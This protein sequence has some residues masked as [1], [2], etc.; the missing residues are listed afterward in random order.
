MPWRLLHE[1]RTK[2]Q[3]PS[4]ACGWNE[5]FFVKRA[6]PSIAACSR[7]RAPLDFACGWGIKNRDNPSLFFIERFKANWGQIA[8]A[9]FLEA[10]GGSGAG[11]SCLGALVGR[12]ILLTGSSRRIAVAHVH[13]CNGAK[14]QDA[15]E[16]KN[17][18]F[19]LTPANFFAK[20]S[21]VPSHR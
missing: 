16:M 12:G 19:G 20:P 17:A 6:A 4:L 10:L 8:L 13:A 15:N 14:G 18:K 3:I 21:V 9:S 2:T 5:T 1:F 7:E 11:A